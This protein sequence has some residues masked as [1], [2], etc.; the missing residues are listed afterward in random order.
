MAIRINVED[1]TSVD[2][3]TMVGPEVAGQESMAPAAWW[4][5]KFVRRGRSAIDVEV[6][7][8]GW[9]VLKL[10]VRTEHGTS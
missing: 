8:F 2:E 1:A 5:S 9:S 3:W 4:A 6:D 10:R 7:V